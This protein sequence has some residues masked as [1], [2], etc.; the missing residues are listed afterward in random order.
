M[1]NQPNITI[2][3]V[4]RE[5]LIKNKQV[6]NKLKTS[7]NI[8]FFLDMIAFPE[9][10]KLIVST[11]QNLIIFESIT[12]KI[13][14]SLE[15]K[16]LKVLQNLNN[17]KNDIRNRANRIYSFFASKGGSYAS[18]HLF[19]IN[20]NDYTVYTKEIIHKHVPKLCFLNFFELSTDLMV[21][22]FN[23]GTIMIFDEPQNLFENYSNDN[24]LID[25]SNIEN[26]NYINI[27]NYKRNI[28]N[29]N[30]N[31]ER[32]SIENNNFPSSSKNNPIDKERQ[33]FKFK[34]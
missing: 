17:N 21:I 6:T 1:G 33:I 11:P 16:G 5:N 8:N 9:E 31:N 26:N 19:S 23:K 10:E 25:D 30:Y 22:A 12:F 14:Q 34:N 4:G 7:N 15:I 28:N 13:I 27:N 20:F 24:N 18:I 32:N 29:N 2:K 3:S